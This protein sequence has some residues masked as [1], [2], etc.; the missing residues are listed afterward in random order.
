MRAKDRLA[1][2]ENVIAKVGIDGDV[3]GEYTR[4][5]ATLNGMESMRATMPP[6]MPQTSPMEAQPP[7]EA[8]QPLMEEGG[9]EGTE[10]A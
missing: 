10:M 2:L 7:M 4:S 8:Q 5:L 3:L 9:L 1:I 6:M